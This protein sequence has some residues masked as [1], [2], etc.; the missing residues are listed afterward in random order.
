MQVE[1]E[2]TEVRNLESVAP[3]DVFRMAASEPGQH[4]MNTCYLVLKEENPK[5]LPSDAV[6]TADVRTG[7]VVIFG[8]HVKVQVAV[9][10]RLVIGWEA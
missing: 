5:S 10:A 2:E 3:G 4:N 7:N 1:F 8:E 9:T 6:L